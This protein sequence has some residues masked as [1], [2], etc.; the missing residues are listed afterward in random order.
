MLTLDPPRDGPSAC[1]L[2]L[3]RTAPPST[4]VEDCFRSLVA[5]VLLQAKR[6]LANP[7]YRTHAA[8]WLR[9]DDARAYAELLGLDPAALVRLLPGR[10]AQ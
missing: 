9:S 2:R 8:R 3:E 6:D 1:G 4:T 5:A 7:G 10:G